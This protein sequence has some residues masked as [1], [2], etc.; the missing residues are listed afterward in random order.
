MIDILLDAFGN[1]S[2]LSDSHIYNWRAPR[3]ASPNTSDDFS[4]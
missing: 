4:G 3:L 1:V 2:Q